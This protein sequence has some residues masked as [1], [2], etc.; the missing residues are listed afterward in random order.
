M[1]KRVPYHELDSKNFLSR[2]QTLSG[3]NCINTFVISPGPLQPES[4]PKTLALIEKYRKLYPILGI[5]LGHQMLGKLWGMQVTKAC[6]PCHGFTKRIH[7]ENTSDGLFKGYPKEVQK[8]FYHSLILKEDQ[9]PSPES[10]KKHN[11]S[12]KVTAVDAT[13]REIVAVSYKIGDNANPIE[14][15]QFHPESFLSQQAEKFKENW[16]AMCINWHSN[17]RRICAIKN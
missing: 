7:I 1:V 14:S 10:T 6:A 11:L 15:V 13:N 4:Y 2:L 3:D 9:R 12:Y 16:L 8:G 17:N 5:C